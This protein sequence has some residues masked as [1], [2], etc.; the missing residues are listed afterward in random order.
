MVNHCRSMGRNQL[1]T[2]LCIYIQQLFPLEDSQE[3]ER[4]VPVIVVS[5]APREVIH[6]GADTIV[7]EAVIEV[8]CRLKEDIRIGEVNRSQVVHC[9]RLH[10]T[11]RC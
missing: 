10:G 11:P 4:T 3:T 7:H 1:E 6:G 8:S 2:I 5:S 9:F